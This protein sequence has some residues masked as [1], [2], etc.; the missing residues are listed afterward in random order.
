M[1]VGKRGNG[2]NLL[3]ICIKVQEKKVS[4]TRVTAGTGGVHNLAYRVEEAVVLIPEVLLKLGFL[5]KT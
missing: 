5:N 2:V 3:I 1:N 4:L